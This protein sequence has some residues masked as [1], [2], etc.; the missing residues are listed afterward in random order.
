MEGMEENTKA[1]AALRQKVDLEIKDH[2]QGTEKQLNL[3]RTDMARQLASL[4]HQF[5]NGVSPLPQPTPAPTSGDSASWMGVARDEPLLGP[6]LSQ[7]PAQ[8]HA[9]EGDVIKLLHKAV[10]PDP[11]AHDAHDAPQG[12][13]PPDAPEDE[14]GFQPD[15]RAARPLQAGFD[16]AMPLDLLLPGH[17]LNK[18]SP[19]SR[20]LARLTLKRCVSDDAVPASLRCAAIVV[21]KRLF[22]F[23]KGR[24][25]MCDLQ[26]AMVLSTP[27]ALPRARL[28]ACLPC[29]RASA[30]ALAAVPCRTLS[31][32]P[33][34]HVDPHP[35]RASCRLWRPMRFQCLC[36][37]AIA[38]TYAAQRY[39]QVMDVETLRLWALRVMGSLPL[40][41]RC[42]FVVVSEAICVFPCDAGGRL[43]LRQTF[44]LTSADH[45]RVYSQG[46]Y[47]EVDTPPPSHCRCEVVK[48]LCFIFPHDGEHNYQVL[49]VPSP[50]RPVAS[51][52]AHTR[53]S[54]SWC[55]ALRQC[56]EWSIER[57]LTPRA[58]G[59]MSRCRKPACLTRSS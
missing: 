43:D 25:G 14:L 40:R 27:C 19:G 20:L 33:W 17:G 47:V 48:H 46:C 51:V 10:L 15:L 34:S 18:S 1:V 26:F 22:L 55:W 29:E 35:A 28:R 45:D 59:L 53:V 2:K 32:A 16:D 11:D 39:T 6:S 56:S 23:P 24:D 21:G 7:H 3:V 50:Y 12:L 13:S 58:R 4:T 9:D 44:V 41:C 42:A 8:A 31:L 57:A 54:A 49:S 36:R 52:R 38:D 30:P 5:A 37:R